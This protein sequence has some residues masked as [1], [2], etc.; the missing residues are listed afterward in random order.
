MDTTRKFLFPL[1][2]SYFGDQETLKSPEHAWQASLKGWETKGEREGLL[3]FHAPPPLSFPPL[4]CTG[5]AGP[6]KHS[7]ARYYGGPKY[8]TIKC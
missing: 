3:P 2:I 4:F 1:T 5:H 7:R 6:E 8:E